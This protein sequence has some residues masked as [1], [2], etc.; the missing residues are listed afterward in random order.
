MLA[1]L[2]AMLPGATS[3]HQASQAAPAA[4]TAKQDGGMIKGAKDA[5]I[6]THTVT[7]T[8][9]GT[10]IVGKAEQAASEAAA[11]QAAALDA[12]HKCAP[13][14]CGTRMCSLVTSIFR[15]MFPVQRGGCRQCH[16]LKDVAKSACLTHICDCRLE[17]L[18]AEML[19]GGEASMETLPEAATGLP[20]QW[21]GPGI[22][23]TLPRGRVMK[24]E[25]CVTTL[26]Q[27]RS[28]EVERCNLRG[29]LGDAFCVPVVEVIA[30]PFTLFSMSAL[31]H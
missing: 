1:G 10:D 22:G 19:V 5:P 11:E 12:V 31:D 16:R 28:V 3:S 8:L 24:A 6:F 14:F 25:V 20:L 13:N 29:R 26:V 9:Q 30:P 17:A 23:T 7:V 21:E 15:E 27:E 4:A 2:L 18:L